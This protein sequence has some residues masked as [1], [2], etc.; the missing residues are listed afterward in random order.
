MDPRGAAAT[1][2]LLALLGD[3]VAHSLSPRMQNAGIQALGLDGVY[4]CLR[5]S[6]GD[7][8]GLI[9]GI[10]G[11]GG[12]GNVTLP[13]KEEAARVVEAPTEAVLRTGACNTFWMEAGVLRGDNTDVVGVRAAVAS[14]LGGP[15]TGARILLLG[16]G[17]AARGVALGLLMDDPERVAIRNRTPAR[18]EELARLLDDPRVKAVAPLPAGDEGWD[19]VVNATRLGLHPADP[20]PLDPGEGRVGAVLDVVYGARPTPLV[21]RARELGIP[22]ADGREMLLQ[23]GMASFRHWWGVPAPEAAMRAALEGP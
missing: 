14:L 15:P 4:L 5:T 1:T 17:G 16:A 10:A 20:L 9:R 7:V 6:Q 12:G 13:H 19:L 23:Q 3:P 11:S 21:E 2:R 18:G 8:A 22:A